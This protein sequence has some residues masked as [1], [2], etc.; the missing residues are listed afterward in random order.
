[1][2]AV[3]SLPRVA[4]VQAAAA[5]GTSTVPLALPVGSWELQMPYTSPFPVDVTG[6]GL[7]ATLPANLDRI[8]PRLRVGRLVVRRP[9]RASIS[10]HVEDTAL[11]PAAATATFGPLAIVPAGAR[12]RVVPVARACGRYVDWY[13]SAAS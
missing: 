13:R 11:A 3:R 9:G 4:P 6:P 10:F 2:A 8:G 12:D 1:M 7:R 5:G